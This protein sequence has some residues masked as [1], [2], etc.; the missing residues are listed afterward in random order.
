MWNHVVLYV[1]T[2]ILEEGRVGWECNQHDIVMG[3]SETHE[4]EC[5]MSGMIFLE[6][7]VV[8]I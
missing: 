2:S 1:D 7:T 3:Y 8:S 4:G 6:N 5:S